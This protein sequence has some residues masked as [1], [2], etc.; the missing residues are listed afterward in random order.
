MLSTVDALC[1]GCA[2]LKRDLSGTTGGGATAAL[3]VELVRFLLLKALFRDV[4]AS[5][6]SP[7]LVVDVAWLALMRRP[8]LYSTV[9]DRLLPADVPAPR[10]LDYDPAGAAS[11]KREWRYRMTH[12]RYLDV[13]HAIPPV[14]FWPVDEMSGGGS[15]SGSG[16]SSSG[17]GASVL[18][19]RAHRQAP[20]TTTQLRV[21]FPTGESWMINTPLATTVRD[22][23]DSIA[24]LKNVSVD[25]V[26]F[27]FGGQWLEDEGRTM[28]NLKIKD[29]CAVQ[30]VFR[31][32][33][34]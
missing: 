24:K 4:T 33:G 1:A 23:K 17:S 31:R 14:L 2:V 22:L 7:S 11:P 21:T 20:Q 15:G 18:G 3:V 25:T 30:C 16:S 13:F 29:G 34:S 5:L 6:L 8:V 32:V 12:A 28:A 10:L 26:R 9:C 27:L 19:K